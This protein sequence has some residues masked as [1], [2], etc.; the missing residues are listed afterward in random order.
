M[1]SFIQTQLVGIIARVLMSIMGGFLINHGASTVQAQGWTGAI[2]TAMAGVLVIVAS[3]VWSLW[4]RK[5]L[6]SSIPAG[7]T[8]LQVLSQHV[9]QAAQMVKD[10]L[11]AE[12]VT[13]PVGTFAATGT[14]APPA[15]PQYKAAQ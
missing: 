15:V 11:A 6:E 13:P 8:A 3:I 14:T 5:K 12:T 7:L 4:G 10:L 2:A 9:P 1:Q